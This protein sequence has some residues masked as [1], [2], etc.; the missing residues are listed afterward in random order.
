VDENH[1]N[2]TKL[3]FKMP[4]Y[5]SYSSLFSTLY[6][7]SSPVG[8]LG[9]GTHYSVFRCAEWFDVT[10]TPLQQGQLHDF[11]VIWD[12]DHDSRVILAIERLYMAGL[13]SPVQFIGE[14]K[15][16]LTL[17]V[18]AKFYFRDT[19]DFFE[20]Y[21]RQV[22]DAIGNIEGD[23]WNSTVGSFDRQLG[24]SHQCITEGIIAADDHRVLT[25]LR[26]IDSLWNLGTKQYAPSEPKEP[27]AM[28][29]AI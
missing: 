15:G 29:D 11:A 23:W 6:D 7:E 16:S 5:P 14:R 19:E 10:L 3:E 12:E 13:F 21:K 2:P 1:N 25:Y 22:Q 24:S 4:T 28:D 20:K 8:H 17:I 9:R 26:N 18:A 27:W